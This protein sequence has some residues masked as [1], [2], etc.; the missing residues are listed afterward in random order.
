MHR[1]THALTL[2]LALLAPAIAGAQET[3]REGGRVGVSLLGG[4]AI[5]GGDGAGAS[6]GLAGLALRFGGAFTPRFHLLGELTLAAAPG[7]EVRGLGEV[8]TLHPALALIG[9]GYIGPSFFVRGG[10]GAG[11][12]TSTTGNLWYLPLPGPRFSGGVGYALWSQGE[13]Q[14]S[15][16]VDV[17]YSM[18]FN[19]RPSFDRLLTVTAHVG[20]DW[21]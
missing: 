11:W 20:F 9:E 13:R 3:A 10:V 5:A 6:A 4:A 12:A 15:V 7:G 2:S 16:A 8:L 1:T 19:A 14:L 17:G 21:Y 18:L